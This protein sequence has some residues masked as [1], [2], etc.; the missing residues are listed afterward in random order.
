MVRADLMEKIMSESN[1]TS[2]PAALEDYRPLADSEL[3]AVSGGT[4][5]DTILEVW[6][7]VRVSFPRVP[8][9]T[10]WGDIVLK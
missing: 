5:F 2:R 1:D 7:S 8:G 10:K 4:V 6:D 3:E 9:N